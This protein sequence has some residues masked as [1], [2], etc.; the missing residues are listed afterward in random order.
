MRAFS[1]F[2]LSSSRPLLACFASLLWSGYSLSAADPATDAPSGQR[3]QVTAE[4]AKTKVRLHEVFKV[5]L[6]VVNVTETPQLIRVM[7][8]SWP[9]HWRA[10]NPQVMNH[11]WDCSKNFPVD[12]TIAPGAAYA[13]E[14]EV[15]VCTPAECQVAVA[16]N[17][18][19]NPALKN[20]VSAGPLSFKMGFTPIG[21]TQIYWSDEI[22]IEIVP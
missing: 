18:R 16:S 21:S 3:F 4:P 5:A 1:F 12:E 22:K 11:G 15:V 20:L 14:L 9:D 13:K 10:S 17:Q 8:C 7:N 6:R 19:T 2:T